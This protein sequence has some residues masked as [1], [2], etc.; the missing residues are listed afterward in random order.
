[1]YIYGSV[2]CVYD[3]FDI[4]VIYAA[5]NFHKPKSDKGETAQQFK[6]NVSSN[7]MGLVLGQC[8]FGYKV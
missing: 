1:M 5:L 4:T 6:A 2:Y 7:Y 3:I 8:S